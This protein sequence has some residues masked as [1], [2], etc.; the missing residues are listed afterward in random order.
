MLATGRLA[1][2]AWLLAWSAHSARGD[3]ST[4]QRDA[5]RET[6]PDLLHGNPGD[7]AGDGTTETPEEAA[8]REGRVARRRAGV[9]V[10]CHRGAVEFAHENS[11]EAY[12]AAFELGADGNEIDIRATQ[13]GVLVCF[14]DDMLDHLLDAYGDVSDYTWDELRRFRFRNPG[15]FGEHCRIPTLV[16]VFELHRRHAGLMH[17]DIKRTELAR[18]VSRLVTNMN[19]WSHILHAPPEVTDPR[20]RPGR[21]KGGLYLDRTE[22]DHVAIQALLEKPGDSL[23]LEDP[24][25][26]A[27]ALGRAFRVPSAQPV[28]PLVSL[29][30]LAAQASSQPKTEA[31]LV[32]ILTNASD[33]NTI[34][35]GAEAELALAERILVRARAADALAAGLSPVAASVLE[36]RVRNRA[37][38]RDW[39]YHGLDGAAALRALMRARNE[40]AVELARFCLWRD[41]P[42]IQPLVNPKWKNP[43]AWTDWRT[44]TIVFRELMQVPGAAT[45]QLC[46]DY[47]A[48]TDEAAAQIGILEFEA[49]A[50]TL[51]HVRPNEETALEL[52]RHRRSDVRG[53]AILLC[54]RHA[55][56]PWARPALEQAAPHALAYLFSSQP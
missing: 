36:E 6:R 16:E 52:L 35:T 18:P 4:P 23:I 50:R 42:A 19:L 11:L 20:F 22:V 43:R 46:R 24:R 5:P 27:V 54:L 28:A 44:K 38:H 40:R 15:P 51:L 33:W 2:L 45:E 48:L 31:E 1:A 25:G 56:Q 9:M 55:D 37:F 47:L 29:P 14:H 30:P 7:E 10:I 41:D 13:D 32:S 17:L 53:R 21:Y 49:A 12:R 8:A 26:A 39:R 3:E 34:A